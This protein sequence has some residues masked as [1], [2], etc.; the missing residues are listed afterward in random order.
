MG[1]LER[2][3]QGGRLAFDA[4]PPGAQRRVR[5]LAGRPG[6]RRISLDALDAELAQAEELF[7]RS[8]DAARAHLDGF[9]LEPPRG[10]PEDPFSAQYEAWAW[11]LYH[12]IS[13][14]SGYT[15]DNEA[16]PFD[17]PAALERPFPYSTG[18][19]AVVGEDLEARGRVLRVL[20]NGRIGGGAAG[21][22]ARLA[23]SA[24]IVE[25]GPGWGNLTVDLLATGFDVTAVEVDA[26]F[27]SLLSARAPAGGRLTVVATDMLSFRPDE[28]MDA[29]V[30]FESFHHCADHRRML[31]HLHEVVAPDGV[32]VF[33]GEPV[34][35]MSY[36]WGPRL[37]GLSLWSTRTYGW[38]E[39]GF[40][41][42]YFAAALARTGW[43]AVH[44]R[45][46]RSPKAD[47]HLAV[48]HG[49]DR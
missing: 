4:L 32:V 47:L 19:A 31:R 28:P 34:Q 35:A 39:L 5:K 13:G 26:G 24:R 9:E 15:L 22:G 36:P 42:R 46:R 30:F 2:V 12:N 1:V 20:G 38:L 18:S 23:P 17:L 33:A 43:H 49:G 10:R 3:G 44:Y 7:A 6:P 21:P 37:D 48:R 27:R 14:R 25:F 8:E 16:S 11:E 45:S 29:A 41:P 40:D